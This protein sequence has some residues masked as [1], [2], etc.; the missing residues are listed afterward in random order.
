MG[1][2]GAVSAAIGNFVNQTYGSSMFG[3]FAA[4]LP[5]SFSAAA[6]SLLLQRSLSRQFQSIIVRTDLSFLLRQS[7]SHS[8][9]AH[10]DQQLASSTPVFFGM[11]ITQYAL[12]TSHFTTSQQHRQRMSISAPTSRCG[13]WP[14]HNNIN[15]VCSRCRHTSV[16]AVHELPRPTAATS[17]QHR[18]CTSI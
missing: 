5:S 2:P 6:S 10:M 15:N 4:L 8:T 7:Q 9:M 11:S 17:Q 12:Y 13:Q 3:S 18:Q 14:R 1:N 16:P